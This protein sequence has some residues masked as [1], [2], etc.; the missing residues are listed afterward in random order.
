MAKYL[1]QSISISEFNFVS[2]LIS[3]PFHFERC[4]KLELLNII[5]INRRK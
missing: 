2:W 4:F 3:I 5:E 1:I